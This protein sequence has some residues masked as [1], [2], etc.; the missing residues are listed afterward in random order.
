MAFQPV[1]AKERTKRVGRRT[2]RKRSR[3]ADAKDGS[4]SCTVP[5]PR[6]YNS[7]LAAILVE[8]LESVSGKVRPR[9]RLIQRRPPAQRPRNE[10][11]RHSPA[12]GPSLHPRWQKRLATRAA[13][14]GSA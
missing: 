5:A 3:Q 6:R 10:L 1:K 4:G 2:R 7:W 14:A 12:P 8:I 11:G 9:G 13:P